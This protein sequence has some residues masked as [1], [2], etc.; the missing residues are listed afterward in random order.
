MNIE[1]ERADFEA[2]WANRGLG[3]G[4]GKKAAADA[5]QPANNLSDNSGYGAEGRL[6]LGGNRIL[7]EWEKS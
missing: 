4:T 1:Q 3:V 2:W 6:L 7:E 5:G